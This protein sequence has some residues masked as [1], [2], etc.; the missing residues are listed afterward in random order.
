[1]QLVAVSW[2]Y[3]QVWAAED[4]QDGAAK[5]ALKIVQQREYFEAEVR[6]RY[7]GGNVLDGDFV[8]DLS[9]THVPTEMLAEFSNTSGSICSNYSRL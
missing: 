4:T 3:V 9:R 6:A 7:N 1:M 5:V 8:L 2:V